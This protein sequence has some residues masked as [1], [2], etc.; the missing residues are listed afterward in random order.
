MFQLKWVEGDCFAV[1]GERTAAS[2]VCICSTAALGAG[3]TQVRQ[4]KEESLEEADRRQ[5]PSRQLTERGFG[6]P[7]RAA[8]NSCDV[9]LPG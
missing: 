1:T 6:H 5:L 8:S 9:D 4:T 2:D 3:F 7:L